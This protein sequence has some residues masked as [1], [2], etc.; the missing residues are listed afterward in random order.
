VPAFIYSELSESLLRFLAW[1][2]ARFAY[3]IRV[4]GHDQI[5]EEGGAVLICNHV[6]FVDWLIVC[7][8]VKRPVRFVMDHSFCRGWVMKQFMNQVKV[9]PIASGG[10]DPAR[11]K[12]AYEI[13][14]AALRDGQ[15]VCLFPEGR[16]TENGKLNSFKPGIMKILKHTPVPVI[17][18][19][20]H[21]LWGSFFSRKSG[22]AMGQ[23]PRGFR[24]RV[25]LRIG[26]AIPAERAQ[27]AMLEERV[28]ALEASTG[29]GG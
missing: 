15:I 5:P 9:I 2:I 18:M 11:L 4:V 27:I 7:A 13:I 21:G 12:K 14:A 20:L 24:S 29:L 16:I 23:W 22:R 1:T 28:R 3:R 8:S 25:E 10:E 26:K 6:S 19:C 17:P